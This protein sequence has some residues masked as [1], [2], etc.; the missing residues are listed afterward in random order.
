MNSDLDPNTS[1]SKQNS[2]LSNKKLIS[3]LLE[4]GLFLR[5]EQWFVLTFLTIDLE[6]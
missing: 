6:N 4:G 5:L 1:V 2:P 3:F